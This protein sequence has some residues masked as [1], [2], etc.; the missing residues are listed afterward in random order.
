VEDRLDVLVHELRSSVAALVA[1]AEAFAAERPRMSPAEARRLVELAVAA[2]RSI[3]RLVADSEAFSIE[4][5][6]IDVE[7]LLDEVVRDR[8]SIDVDPGLVLLADPVRLRQAIG[9]LLDNALRHGSVVRV[10]ARADGDDVRIAVSDDGPGVPAGL[11]VFASGVSGVGSTGYGLAVAK[12]I[13]AG[14][15]GRIEV[16]SKPAAGA[17]FT[18]VLPSG[19]G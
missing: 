1:I 18:L 13:A 6:P 3:D 5:R 4:A 7:R 9:N 8:A 16:S 15:G 12:A 2:G 11:D 17:T 19:V 14:H 10:V